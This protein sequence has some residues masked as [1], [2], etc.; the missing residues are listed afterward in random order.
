MCTIDI[1]AG[2]MIEDD[3]IELNNEDLK[4]Q[5]HQVTNIREFGSC[6]YITQ[7]RQN[8]FTKYIK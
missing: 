3:G 2:K 1:K 8:T 5:Y 4:R 6:Q 7:S